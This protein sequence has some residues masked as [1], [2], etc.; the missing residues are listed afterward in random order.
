MFT[1][2]RLK[3]DCTNIVSSPACTAVHTVHP[4]ILWRGPGD[5]GRGHASDA[6]D[7]EKRMIRPGPGHW[8]SQS[9]CRDHSVSG[10]RTDI[11]LNGHNLI[12]VMWPD[13]P[14]QDFRHTSIWFLT[15]SLKWCSNHLTWCIH[16]VQRRAALASVCDHTPRPRMFSW[17]LQVSALHGVCS[18][19]FELKQNF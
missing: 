16:V 5:T 12:I 17:I 14:C 8:T 19:T 15:F 6:T 7:V 1:A 4:E 9:R 2:R 11:G 3:A 18:I 13:S 10:H